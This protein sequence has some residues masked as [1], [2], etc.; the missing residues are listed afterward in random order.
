[1]GVPGNR[2]MIENRS[3][4]TIENAKF[5]LPMVRRRG[6]KSVILVTSPYHA[7]RSAKVFRKLFS[8][9]GI[10]II[11]CPVENSI[12]NPDRW[13]T[14]HEDTQF[15]VWEYVALVLYFFKGF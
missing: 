1:M 13:W 3:L 10:R 5:S 6:F 9:Y 4:S 15:V 2:I 12:F 7:F 8:P 11:V 14:R